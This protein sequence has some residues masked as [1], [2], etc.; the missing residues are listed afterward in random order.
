MQESPNLSMRV[1]FQPQDIPGLISFWNFQQSGEQFVAEQGEPYCLYSQ[2][3]P[4]QVIED[5]DAAYGGK[6]LVLE[7]GQWLSIPRKQCPRLDI[8]GK[9]GHLTVMAWM[10][11]GKTR[12]DHCEFIAGM[13][14]ESNWGRQY[15]LFLNI[16]VWGPH[17]RIFGHL[18]HVG[19][20]TPG[21]KYCMDG[22]M[23]AS[24]IET[25][26]WVSVAMSYDGQVG[27]S[28]LNG[29]LDAHAGLNPYAMAGG[30]N[31]GGEKGS[32]F[33]VGAVDRSGEIGNYFCG[34][35]AAL[36]VYDRALT[37]A[38]IHRLGYPETVV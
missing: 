35:L 34:H 3:G 32:D 15:G 4:L 37:P 31:D 20:P 18:S 28:W 36:A 14:N 6:A 5:K 26:T 22:S 17:H 19:G 12:V 2:S 27:C 23:G 13:W 10:K 1:P 21:Y 30:L 24:E 38:E 7:E 8:H 9:E 11:R 25:D 16:M 29:C 33:T